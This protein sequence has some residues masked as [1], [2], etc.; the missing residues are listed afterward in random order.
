M[1][2]PLT[3]P[4]RAIFCDLR[5]DEVF[6]ILPLQDVTLDD[7][8][9][10]PGSLTGT[11]PVPNQAIAARAARIAEGRTSVYL[12][13]GGDLWWG[14]IIWTST[15]ASTDRGIVTLEIQAATFDSYAGR[16]IIR[17]DLSWPAGTDQLEIARGLWRALQGQP[18][19]V[20]DPTT[21][22]GGNILVSYGTE[23]SGVTR[24]QSYLD[25]DE[26][27]Y[28]DALSQLAAL[29]NGFEYHIAVYRD[30]TDGTRVRRLRL[31]GPRIATGSTDLVLDMPGS[32]LAYSFPRDATRGGT[33]A[34]AQG[35]SANTDSSEESRPMV[36]AEAVADDLIGAG[37]PRI[38][39]TTT[40]SDITD[41]AT[42]DRLAATQ[43]AA[44]EGAVV[45]PEVTIRLDD[46]VPP[47]LLGRTARL[48]INDVWYA[49]GFDSRF[50]IIGVK[51]T[52][53][54]RGVPDT[55]DLYLEEVASA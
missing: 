16:R 35:G 40:Y 30:P 41:Q 25:G 50:R 4:Y 2:G 6:D 36:S 52:P 39:L 21:R 15:L 23:K 53:P 31:G 24:A 44:A 42:L 54:Q 19:E 8:I 11:I 27:T 46:L 20:P 48:R 51:V 12:E 55:A 26:T 17:T 9:G 32:V 43:L 34:V 3:T 37:W 10:K 18:P 45:I 22:P 28:D 47:Q 29:D 14:G 1:T 33:T 5:N 13:R 38:D 7:Y 49:T